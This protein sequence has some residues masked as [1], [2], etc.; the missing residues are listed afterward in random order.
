MT[1]HTHI[2]ARPSGNRVHLV[3]WSGDLRIELFLEPDQAERAAEVLQEAARHAR[4]PRQPA[5]PQEQSVP[6]APT[7]S[8]PSEPQALTIA[9]AC[10]ALRISDGLCRK[11][12]RSGRLRGVQM[13]RRVLIPRESVLHVLA[14]D[15]PER[16]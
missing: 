15:P 4:P 2:T 7:P 14:A 12:L 3:V 9:E 8:V 10:K 6:A 5:P 13:G 1:N 16:L 11:M